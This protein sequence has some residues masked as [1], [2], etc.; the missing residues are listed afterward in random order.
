MRCHDRVRNE[1]GY[2]LSSCAICGKLDEKVS[3]GEWV[4]GWPE[5]T[6]APPEFE[7]LDWCMQPVKAADL[8][9]FRC[10]ACGAY[11]N[12][13]KSES[14]FLGGNSSYDR[15][16]LSRHLP[17]SAGDLTDS[18]AEV[19][20]EAARLLTLDLAKVGDFEGLDRLIR[21]TDSTV[22]FAALDT[23]A[24]LV[25][26]QYDPVR[27]VGAGPTCLGKRVF[28]VVSLE[29][30]LRELFAGPPSVAEASARV[31]ALHLLRQ[32][33]RAE[34]ESLLESD[35]AGARSGALTAVCRAGDPIDREWQL[36]RLQRAAEKGADLPA[37]A[38]ELLDS[39]VYVESEA[40]TA[41]RSL[42]LHH[43]R[44]ATWTPVRRLLTSAKP[45]IWPYC[46][47]PRHPG[48]RPRIWAA[49][50]TA[51]RDL[52]SGALG[53]PPGT[54]DLT[55]VV[56]TLKKIARRKD[57]SGSAARAALEQ[58]VRMGARQRARR[59]VQP[60]PGPARRGARRAGRRR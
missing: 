29:P 8:Y 59:K 39:A 43:A 27:G 38:L 12:V 31:L 13:V 46:T 36:D 45:A 2:R 40:Y 14:Y 10:P 11:Y 25:A 1:G 15:Y 47:T 51:L 32:G 54:L 3:W 48:S 44:N 56:P 53:N 57:D 9:L 4:Q 23:L 5:V 42:T 55:P 41:A 19:R 50:A 52:A 7:R 37:A 34:V 35:H 49:V 58:T 21:H 6:P 17:H 18:D 33:R 22:Q 16:E 60:T 20:T 30:T 26:P 28:D 24:V